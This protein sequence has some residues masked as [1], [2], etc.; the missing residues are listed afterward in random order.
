[1]QAKKVEL[2]LPL[3]QLRHI[4]KIPI[5]KAKCME[6]LESFYEAVTS[7]GN[8]CLVIESES[9]GNEKSGHSWLK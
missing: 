5:L 9:H 7:Y 6:G 8:M 3:A 1:M 4:F 2:P